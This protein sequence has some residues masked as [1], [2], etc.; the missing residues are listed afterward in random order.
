MV[1]S[2]IIWYGVV[3]CGAVRCGA[4]QCGA[5]WCGG[6]VT[7]IILMLCADCDS[8]DHLIH[9]LACTQVSQQV[10]LLGVLCWACSP[11]WPLVSSPSSAPGGAT[12]RRALLHLLMRRVCTMKL[13]TQTVYRCS[14]A[15]H[16]SLWNK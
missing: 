14:P 6:M 8:I 1:T 7:L 5:V 16:T 11:V 15:Q 9:A 13:F 3:W 10:L 4:V 12:T 2:G